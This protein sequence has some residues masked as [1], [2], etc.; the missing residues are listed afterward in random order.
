M[1][2]PRRASRADPCRAVLGVY[3]AQLALR[4]ALPKGAEKPASHLTRPPCP[5]TDLPTSSY[6]R[7]HQH[8]HRAVPRHAARERD[9][10]A[11]DAV[12]RVR[13][14]VGCGPRGVPPPDA[15]QRHAARIGVQL[16]CARRCHAALS[17]GYDNKLEHQSPEDAYFFASPIDVDIKLSDEEGRK[18]VE[19][20][21]EKEKED[22]VVSGLFRRRLGQREDAYFVLVSISRRMADVAKERDIW[23]PSF[24]LPADTNATIEMEVGI[25]DCLHSEFEYNK[26]NYHLKDV[27]MGKIYFLLVRIKIKIKHMELSIIRRET[28]DAHTRTN[29]PAPS[30]L[31]P[32]LPLQRPPL[33]R[34]SPCALR[35]RARSSLVDAFRAHVLPEL[36]ARAWLFVLSGTLRRVPAEDA[37]ID[38]L[39]GGYPAW[40][41]GA[42]TCANW[43]GNGPRLPRAASG[44]G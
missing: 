41:R 17:S 39:G 44:S 15:L 8:Q 11:A 38:A 40:S 43:R 35:R 9:A 13:Q 31:R 7:V 29:P 42:R 28:T 20:E 21:S 36:R 3:C 5:I 25:E 4:H 18:Q 26:S 32:L 6:A 24:P 10:P 12:A 37:D 2:S 34:V 1:P 23:V 14:G 16:A 22:A 27:I 19:I 30:S 33:D